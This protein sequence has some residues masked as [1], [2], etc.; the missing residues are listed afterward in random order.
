[1]IIKEIGGSAGCD[2]ALVA[3]GEENVEALER[4]GLEGKI[5]KLK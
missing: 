4:C 1:L 3:F 2:S 5:V